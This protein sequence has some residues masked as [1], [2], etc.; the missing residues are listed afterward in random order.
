M[1]FPGTVSLGSTSLQD[2]HGGLP[3]GWYIICPVGGPGVASR[4]GSAGHKMTIGT[5]TRSTTPVL[6]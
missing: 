2:G 3:D 6:V 4:E 1:A 5:I